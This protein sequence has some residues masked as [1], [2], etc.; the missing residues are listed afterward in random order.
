MELVKIVKER[1]IPTK[2]MVLVNLESMVEPDTVIAKGTVP[3][4]DIHELRLHRS[5]NIG[6]ED[7]K[8]HIVKYKG[9]NVDQDEVIAIARSFFGRK[10]RVA[11]SP[12]DGVIESFSSSSGRMMIRGHPVPVEVNAHLPGRITEIYPGEGAS[13]E[14]EGYR[15][16]GL[17]GV[18]GETHG[19]L[20][21]AVESGESP[22]TSSE[23]KPEYNG[24]ILVGGSVATIDALR[25]AVRIGVQG[26][27]VG[28]I[29]QK[30]LTY[31]LGYEIGVGVTGNENIGLT[32]I[33]TEGFGVNPIPVDKF[34]AFRELSGK[35]TCIDGTTHIRSRALRPEIIVPS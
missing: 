1:R 26:I 14:T 10:S 19:S 2:G 27:I 11:R 33:L 21:L 22:L 4:T 12:I 20:A 3:S 15:F 5:L 35:L 25:E 32:L 34:Q 17:F 7:V 30:D 24:T 13:V 16:N 29:D 8:N 6:P 23:I 9:E 28:G 31:F 18:G